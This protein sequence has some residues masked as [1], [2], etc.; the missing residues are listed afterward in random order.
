MQAPPTAKPSPPLGGARLGEGPKAVI[1]LASSLQQQGF[2]V[3]TGNFTSGSFP[4]LLGGGVIGVKE[5]PK[6]SPKE[7]QVVMAVSTIRGNKVALIKRTESWA[8][9]N[10]PIEEAFLGALRDRFGIP[11]VIEN[12]LTRVTKGALE[13]GVTANGK[14]VTGDEC[15]REKIAEAG[16]ANAAFEALRRRRIPARPQRFPGLPPHQRPPRRPA[17]R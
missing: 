9:D 17:R 13:W 2:K 8:P 1:K 4:E 10:L 12:F 16:Y 14:V 11:G 3:F 7:G 6:E 5:G 15:F